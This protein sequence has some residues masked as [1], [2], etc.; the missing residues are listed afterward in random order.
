MASILFHFDKKFYLDDPVHA[1]IFDENNKKPCIW[2]RHFKLI[3]LSTAARI[4]VR[5]AA[6]DGG[7]K[8]GV[9]LPMPH[10]SGGK[11]AL[12]LSFKGRNAEEFDR[13]YQSR[14]QAT[15]Q[16]AYDFNDTILNRFPKYFGK[17]HLPHLKPQE[18][19][20]LKLLMHGYSYKDIETQV[21]RQDGKGNLSYKQINN[22]YVPD[23]VK[24]LGVKNRQHACAM[25]GHWGYYHDLG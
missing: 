14:Q 19:Q 7:L 23:I 11:G 18:K 13:F 6:E 3:N 17:P 15:E 21:Q 1:Y 25:I 9:M 20:I 12:T 2:H 24:K 22:R 10:W 5:E 16:F 4:V 8:F